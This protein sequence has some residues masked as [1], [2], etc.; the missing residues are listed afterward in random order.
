M[1]HPTDPGRSVWAPVCAVPDFIA[2]AVADVA[3]K[4]VRPT[5]TCVPAPP[6]HFFCVQHTKYAK[7]CQRGGARHGVQ[8][9]ARPANPAFHALRQCFGPSSL[10]EDLYDAL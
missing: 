7:P 1:P 10:E 2:N 9:G 8:T 6:D 3:C 5:M 4:Q